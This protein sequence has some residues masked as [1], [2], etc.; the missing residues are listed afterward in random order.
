MTEQK[1][2]LKRGVTTSTFWMGL[3]TAAPLILDIAKSFLDNAPQDSQMSKIGLPVIMAAYAIY[4]ATVKKADIQAHAPVGTGI[5]E[6]T[7]KAAQEAIPPQ[8]AAVIAAGAQVLA[9]RLTDSE[10][11]DGLQDDEEV[12]L[13]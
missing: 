6:E 12:V 5:S 4:R 9:Q 11:A 10:G 2:T 8:Y 7:L 1:T 13:Q 3:I